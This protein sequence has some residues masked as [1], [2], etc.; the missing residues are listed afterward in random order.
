MADVAGHRDDRVRRAVRRPPEVADRRRGQGPDAGLVAADL[1]AERAV[2]EHRLLEQDLGVL[3]RVVE[4]RADL[5]DDHRALAVDLVVGEARPDDQLAEDVHRPRRLAPRDADPVDRRLAVGGR[6]ERAADALDRLARSPG[7]TGYA[8]VPLN[9]MC[10]MKWATPASSGVSRREP[11]RTYAAME[12]ER[13]PGSR[14]LMTRGPVG[15]RGPFEHRGRWYR[16][17]SATPARPAP[18]ERAGRCRDSGG[19]STSA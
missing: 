17:R 1:A 15:Q 6:V 12:T 16:K 2:P 4:V 19:E 9:V 14:A 5:L 8:V 18:T 3:G 7:S 11:A 10:S 13:A